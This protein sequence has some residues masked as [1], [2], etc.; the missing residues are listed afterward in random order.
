MG[1][2]WQRPLAAPGE[3]CE[4]ILERLDWNAEAVGHLL[5]VSAALVAASE[6]LFVR[7][8][9]DV[10]GPCASG[11]PGDGGGIEPRV[12]PRRETI[13]LTVFPERLPEKMDE[14]Q[15]E[16]L[17]VIAER[18]RGDAVSREALEERLAERAGA[19]G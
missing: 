5:D 9:A 19:D 1:R 10:A 8:L 11:E 6:N 14:K 12:R 16:I 3:M 4:A 2:R 17:A 7:E 13:R 15:T 18:Q